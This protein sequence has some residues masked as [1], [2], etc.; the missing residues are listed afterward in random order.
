MS[1]RRL[2]DIPHAHLPSLMASTPCV[3]GTTAP[4]PQ[5]PRSDVFTA[6]S[7]PTSD[8]NAFSALL[9]GKSANKAGGTPRQRLTGLAA[10][11][12]LTSLSLSLNFHTL[13]I[14][15]IDADPSESRFKTDSVPRKSISTG[16][17]CFTNSK[18]P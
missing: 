14:S 16:R 10:R 6:V 7:S 13:T 11:V 18:K 17:R 15:V 2:P 12:C 8:S 1:P 5:K 3:A 9:A 4:S